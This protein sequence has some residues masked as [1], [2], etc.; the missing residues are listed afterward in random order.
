MRGLLCFGVSRPS[1]LHLQRIDIPAPT[2]QGCDECPPFFA[3]TTRTTFQSHFD[4]RI[5]GGARPRTPGEDP[6]MLVWLRHRD[7]VANAGMAGLVALADAL[8]PAAMVM[9]PPEPAPISTMTWTLDVLT[10]NP[11]S[12]SGWWLVENLAQVTREA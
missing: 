5:A 9:F 2:V 6:A 8:P 3:T 4:S 11:A 12:A 7:L 10:D 1:S